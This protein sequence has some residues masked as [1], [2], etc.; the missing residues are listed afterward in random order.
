MHTFWAQGY[1]STSLQDLL[2]AM[3]LSKSSL[4]QR[5]GDK[6]QLFDYC[7]RHY[8]NT[9]ANA[10]LEQLQTSD[11]GRAFIE[12]SFYAIADNPEYNHGQWGCLLMNTANEF[13][14]RD[15]QFTSGIDHG[16]SAFI[17]VFQAAVQ[18][19]QYEGE[20][21]AEKNAEDL[22]RYL[23]SNISGLKTLIKAGTCPDDAR[24]IAAIAL[25]ALD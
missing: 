10:M 9:Q 13:G 2:K 17:R 11:S 24:A 5:F 6:A 1:E 23:V 16:V 19:A 21:N 22:A 8:C 7:L 14:R 12:R 18:Q 3:G 4:Y 15:P 20:I 25:Q